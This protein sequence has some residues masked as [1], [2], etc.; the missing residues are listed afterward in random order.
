VPFQATRKATSSGL[1]LS[2][3]NSAK[4]AFGMARATGNLPL[5]I[6]AGALDAGLAVA[7]SYLSSKGRS[8]VAQAPLSIRTT[9]VPAAKQMSIKGTMRGAWSGAVNVQTFPDGLLIHQRVYVGEITA[10]AVT[11]NAY[12]YDGIGLN[13]TFVGPSTGVAGVSNMYPVFPMV[14]GGPNDIS[15]APVYSTAWKQSYFFPNTLLVSTVANN[16]EFWRPVEF[17]IH[18]VPVCPT[19]TGGS[20]AMA[21]SAT[22]PDEYF[23]SIAG[24]SSAGA[25]NSFYNMSQSPY[26]VNVPL[27]QSASLTGI[28]PCNEGIAQSGN[29]W[30]RCR[31]DESGSTNVDPNRSRQLCAGCIVLNVA[32]NTASASQVAY[33]HI[34]ADY[35][36]LFKGQHASYAASGSYTFY[37]KPVSDTL[38]RIVTRMRD[39]MRELRSVDPLV[40]STAQR[41]AIGRM[42]FSDDD[43]VSVLKLLEILS[44]KYSIEE[45]VLLERTSRMVDGKSP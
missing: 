36:Y 23:G 42:D 12:L 16:F 4:S 30:L 40:R 22:D 17:N 32:D 28:H 21:Y 43:M 41:Q 18:Y 1:G 29:G 11:G 8:T 24:S 5:S 7:E 15:T 14:A 3:L 38:T 44:K 34:F 35:V 2:L 19:S 10:A 31:M 20:F 9:S 6:A 45:P 13:N 27:W 25:S 37:M 26:F 33:G 39:R